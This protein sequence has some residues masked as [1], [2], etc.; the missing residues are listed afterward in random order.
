MQWQ[1][2]PKLK[3]RAVTRKFS[4]MLTVCD[5]QFQGSSARSYVTATTFLN[6]NTAGRQ[7]THSSR[8]MLLPLEGRTAESS[9]NNLLLWVMAQRD[10]KVPQTS[11]L[12]LTI[13]CQ[14]SNSV[15]KPSKV[16]GKKIFVKVTKTFEHIKCLMRDFKTYSSLIKSC[17][18]GST[19]S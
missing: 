4:P 1:P 8:Q 18:W 19:P 5:V 7:G 3:S 6:S 13:A 16:E 9:P 17:N 10:Q 15:Y 2:S 12:E 11:P 14:P